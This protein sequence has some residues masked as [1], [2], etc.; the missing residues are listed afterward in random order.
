M[1]KNKRIAAVIP[2]F[3]EAESIRKVLEEIPKWVDVVVVADNGST[4]GTGDIAERAGAEVV[5]EKRR[6]YG[7]ACLAGIAALPKPNSK[8]APEIVGFLDADF[9]DNPKE[10]E[11]LVDPILSGEFDLVIGSRSTGQ[12]ERRALGLT[13][14]FGN[15]LSCKLI[16]LLFGG[17]FSDLGPFRAIRWTSFHELGM[18]DK[19]FG[20]TVQMQI[21]A[22]KKGLRVREVPVTYRRRAAGKSKVSGTIRGIF[23]AG[24]TILY[25]VF[26]EA[27]DSRTKGVN[28]SSRLHSE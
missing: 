19:D 15:W 6:G 17:N 21:R 10:F 5:V 27:W 8:N 24:T 23:G 2:A 1:R 3:N 28:R 4:D 12:S 18:D 13:Q 14:R 25:V 9:S 20:W 22:L 26:K 7:S 16:G 11:E